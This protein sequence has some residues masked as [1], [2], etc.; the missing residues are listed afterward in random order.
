MRTSLLAGVAVIGLTTAG[1]AFAQES[2]TTDS[3]TAAPAAPAAQGGAA[4][5]PAGDAGGSYGSY[6]NTE[7]SSFA[8]TITGDYS[9]DD[10]M[11]KD[12]MASDGTSVGSVS[13]LLIG[14]DGSVQN[15]LVDVGGF[16]GIGTH[17]VALDLDQIQMQK[18]EGSDT[19]NLTVA[20]T[21]DQIEALPA[22][23]QT[24]NGWA[25]V[26]DE[27]PVAPAAST[28]AATPAPAPA[29]PA[30]TAPAAPAA[31]AA[32]APATTEPAQQ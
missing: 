3:G 25:E 8:G 29:A 31:P 20:M 26:K 7:P 5:A 9:A 21:K 27:P 6:K 14:N 19:Q 17:T 32:T 2:S 1:L 22:V 12:I 10:L 13:D 23:E 18:A 28:P 16:L 24:D 11:G 30:A 4:T 15:V